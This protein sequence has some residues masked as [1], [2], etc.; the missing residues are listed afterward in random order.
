[1]SS[2]RMVRR[3]K[4]RQQLQR[5]SAKREELRK[6]LNDPTL[7]IDA[8]FEVLAKFEKMPRDSCKVRLSRRCSITGRVRGVYRKFSLCRNELRRR[9]MAGEV[10]GLVKSSW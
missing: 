4:K 1:M 6:Q 10:P 2:Q 7:D 3:E 8:K 9:A 5:L